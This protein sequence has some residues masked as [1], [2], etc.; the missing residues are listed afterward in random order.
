MAIAVFAFL[1]STFFLLI[2]NGINAIEIMLSCTEIAI[3]TAIIILAF[4]PPLL[5]I[6]KAKL[7]LS[8]QLMIITP[9]IFPCN[10]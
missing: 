3:L 8:Y 7:T 1:N 2:T 10:Y 5:P 4:V 9:S 6:L